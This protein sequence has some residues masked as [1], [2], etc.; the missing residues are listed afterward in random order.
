[1]GGSAVR[2][3]E[4]K[5]R[6]GAPAREAARRRSARSV[7]LDDVRLANPSGSSSPTQ[8]YPPPRNIHVAAAASPRH[9]PRP[10]KTTRLHGTSTWQPRRRRDTSL[11]RSIFQPRL[12]R[13]DGRPRRPGTGARAS[14]ARAQVAILLRGVP[15]RDWSS[16]TKEGSCCAF[17]TGWPSMPS[18]TRP[19]G[20]SQLEAV[21]SWRENIIEP[22]EALGYEVNVFVATYRCS[23]G[24]M[25]VERELL[26]ALAPYVRGVY[27]G[28]QE[29]SSQFSV[30]SRARRRA[31]SPSRRV[32]APP[33][34]RRGD[35]VEADRGAAAAATRIVRRDESRRRRGRDADIP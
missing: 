34:P 30:V 17:A 24:R 21:R 11:G 22:A 1:M 32:A 31:D 15:F 2:R 27:I 23:N 35:A 13:R 33:R 12:R 3:G 6:G 28:A 20:G 19:S 26:P 14:R 4:T 29:N 16:R 10:L 25:L 18:P 8:N 7:G 9:V 5:V